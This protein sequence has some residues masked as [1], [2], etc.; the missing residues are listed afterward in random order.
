MSQ[1][2]WYHDKAAKCDRMALAS[3]VAATRARHIK[4]RDNWREIAAR[5]DAAEE[6]AKQRKE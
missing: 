3:A 5:I 4:D 2:G 1:S 6:A